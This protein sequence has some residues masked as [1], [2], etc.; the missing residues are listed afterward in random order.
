MEI[1]SVEEKCDICGSHKAIEVPNV[2]K[3][4]E[5]AVV[6]ICADCGLVA[7]RKKATPEEMAAFWENV[8][9]K[10]SYKPEANPEVRSRHMF[11]TEFIK[12]HVGYK[13]KLIV[14]IGAGEGQFLE[15]IKNDGGNVFG[16]ESSSENCALLKK[17]N[18]DYY[19]GFIESYSGDVK[20]DVATL[21]FTLQN[22]Q[23]ATDMI[24]ASRNLIKD[25]GH[26]FIEMGSRIMVP[27][28]KPMGTYFSTYIQNYQPYHF[29]F[30]ALQRLL[31]KCG[32]EVEVTNNFWDDN[33]LCV[34]AKKVS[35][36]KKVEYTENSREEIYNWFSRWDQESDLMRQYVKI[37]NLNYS[38]FDK[39]TFYK[40]R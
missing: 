21:V 25:G 10:E 11:G 4:T 38:F 17:R 22:S 6:H 29:S 7:Y 39:H 1:L 40:N 32:F 3:Y 13:N 24:M 37:P 28:K 9:F 12:K 19:N 30:S 27:F 15:I 23:S 33:L 2:R 35:M 31:A 14:D 36:D 34:L 18:I 8:G 16:I 26:L 5:G 20:G